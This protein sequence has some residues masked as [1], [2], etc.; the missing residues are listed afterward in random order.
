MF[1]YLLQGLF[2]V[3][4]LPGGRDKCNGS[5]KSRGNQRI[6]ETHFGKNL[7]F[8]ISLKTLKILSLG[9]VNGFSSADLWII[10]FYKLIMAL[11]SRGMW[12][13]FI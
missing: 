4:C 3:G 5:K 9:K 13:G 2:R 8:D 12:R 10:L 11:G 7:V 6:G 1:R